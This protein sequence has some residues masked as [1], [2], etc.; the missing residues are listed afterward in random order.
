MRSCFG[1]GG[2]M[3]VVQQQGIVWPKYKDCIPTMSTQIT[4][5]Q[6]KDL[7]DHLLECVRSKDDESVDALKVAW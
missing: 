6:P 3:T 7:A 4:S 2:A 5:C 1:I